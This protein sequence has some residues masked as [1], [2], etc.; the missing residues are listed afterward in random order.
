MSIAPAQAADCTN[1]SRPEGSVIYNADFN[2]PQYC[3]GSEWIAF[4]ALNPAAGGGNCSNPV[5]AEGII[6]YN[7]SFKVLQYCDGT[8]WRGVG[9]SG[10]SGSFLGFTDL[11][12]QTTSTLVT[13]NILQASLAGNVSISGDGSPEYRICADDACNTVNHTWAT[14]AGSIDDGEFLQLRLT[15][16]AAYDTMNSATVTVGTAS[17][18][19]DVKNTGNPGFVL[20]ANSSGSTSSITIPATAQA[21]DLCIILNGARQYTSVPTSVTPAGFTVVAEFTRED[22]NFR[23]RSILSAKKLAPGDPGSSLTG[24]DATLSNQFEDWIVAV[25]RPT[26]S[27]NSFTANSING[28]GTGD[29]PAPQ[30]ITASGAATLPAFLFGAFY[31]G[32]DGNTDSATPAMSEITGSTDDI[33]LKYKL[34]GPGDTPA[35]HT[36]DMD[37]EGSQVMSSGYLTF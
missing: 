14:T 6:L 27:F 4:G 10:P 9:G 5:R 20:I 32:I 3:N 1:P 19:W 25:F 12:D 31:G 37:D 29:D 28:E 26:G 36:V 7:S 17:D 11:T 16:S 21:G 30:T 33:Y 23:V 34:Y 24:M 8:N 2:V 13:S 15:S 35:D 22:D 18:Q